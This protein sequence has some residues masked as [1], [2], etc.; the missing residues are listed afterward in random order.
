LALVWRHRPAIPWRP[1]GT[2]AGVLVLLL[3]PLLILRPTASSGDV[4]WIPRPSLGSL[5]FFAFDFAG[6]R[7]AGVIAAAFFGLLAALLALGRVSLSSRKIWFLWMAVAWLAAPI[8]VA[9]VFS[10]WVKPVFM[11]RYLIECVPALALILALAISRLRNWAAV[12][13]LAV[14]FI[15]MFRQG[16]REKFTH[17]ASWREAARYIASNTSGDDAVICYP[18]FSATSLSYYLLRAQA[19]RNEMPLSIANG[20]YLPGGGGRDPDPAMNVIDSLAADHSRVWL[21]TTPMYG[22]GLNRGWSSKIKAA[23]TI[24]FRGKKFVHY[25]DPNGQSID[26]FCYE[27][28]EDGLR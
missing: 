22:E 17:G 20:P 1:L 12:A 18:Y 26:V 23:L 4:D 10:L 16:V 13:T 2:A 21:V 14:F 6:G 24:Q 11:S 25:D 19:P 8:G 28:K 15:L 9:F 27:R 7:A 5:Y 3:L